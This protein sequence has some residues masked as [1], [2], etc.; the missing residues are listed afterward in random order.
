MPS[1]SG[2][3]SPYLCDDCISSVEDIGCSCCWNTAFEQEGL[4]QDLL[5]FVKP[6]HLQWVGCKN[7]YLKINI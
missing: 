5:W 1:F 3:S 6:T 4:P 7:L 2:G